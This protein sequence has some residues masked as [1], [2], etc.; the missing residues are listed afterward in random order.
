MSD[1]DS[2][3]IAPEGSVSDAPEEEKLSAVLARLVETGRAYAEAEIDRQKLRAIIVTSGLR[4]VAILG[5]VSLILLFGILITLML[6]LVIALAPL[7]TPLGATAAVVV[8]GLLVVAI[9]LLVARNRVRSLLG[10]PAE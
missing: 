4:T 6:G 1:K 9:L 5:L 8:A 2:L 7:L 3:P 10:D